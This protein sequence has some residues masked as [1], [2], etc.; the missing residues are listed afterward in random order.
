[1]SQSLLFYRY[2]HATG[3]DRQSY[4]HMSSTASF[5]FSICVYVVL[6]DCGLL[7]VSSHE[8][9]KSTFPA[10]CQHYTN[11]PQHIYYQRKNSTYLHTVKC[12]LL[13][14]CRFVAKLLLLW[15]NTTI[16]F[17]IHFHIIERSIKFCLTFH[18]RCDFVINC[19]FQVNFILI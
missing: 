2:H 7:K 13:T 15:G 19:K 14:T 5:S 6:R 9:V 3:K 12:T 16:V 8:E 4:R 1:M 17:P 18:S 11:Y 10:S